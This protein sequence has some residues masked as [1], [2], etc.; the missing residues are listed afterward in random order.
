ML[1]DY[2]S[3]FDLSLSIDILYKTNNFCKML[4]ASERLFMKKTILDDG[5]HQYL[6]DG[7]SFIVPPGIP[8]LMN[9]HNTQVPKDINP[10]EKAKRA[11]NKRAYVHFYMHDKYFSDVLTST[12]K[13][14]DLLKQFDGVI[15]P[16]CSM[17]I[18]QVPCLQQ[19]NT[20]FNRAVGFYLQKNGI[21]VIPNVRWSDESS[22]EYC[23][24][25]V[26]ANDIVAISTHGCIRSKAEKEMYRKGLY[27][28][29]TVLT[30]HDVIVHGYM[31]ESVFGEFTNYTTFHRYASQFER[32]HQKEGA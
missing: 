1:F 26:P 4:Y 11:T 31:P 2:Y 19:V 8:V 28:M 32:T 16:D 23:F 17:L 3:I 9:L 6:T 12:T 25:G 30:P 21:P 10:F 22:F 14:L 5:F 20:Y 27:E 15:T 18:G 13:Y 24:L 29:L 7:A